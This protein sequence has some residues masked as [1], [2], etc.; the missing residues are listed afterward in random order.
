MF[1][2]STVKSGMFFCLK[3]TL[4]SV[5]L[6]WMTFLK[7]PLLFCFWNILSLFESI[8]VWLWEL[9]DPKKGYAVVGLDE[10]MNECLFA[11]F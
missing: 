11:N 8:Y 6:W 4:V 5:V 1:V 3:Q 10:G 9:Y 7:L 2:I